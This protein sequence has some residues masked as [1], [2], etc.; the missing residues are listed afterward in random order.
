MRRNRRGGLALGLVLAA[1]SLT[2]AGCGGGGAADT[3]G[4]ATA[5]AGIPATGPG[6]EAARAEYLALTTRTNATIAS[7]NERL[8]AAEKS[9]DWD[10]LAA[11]FGD[12]ADTLADARSGVQAIDFPEPVRQQADQVVA[13]AATARALSRELAASA[14]THRLDRARIAAWAAAL[15]EASGRSA[16]L[17]SALGLPAVPAG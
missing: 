10:T 17:R 9:G 16:A 14:R 6:I 8:T 4:T 1:L 5:A 3:G 13:S 15:A 12:L 2:A 7:I 11:G